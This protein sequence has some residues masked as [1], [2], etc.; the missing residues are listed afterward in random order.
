MST[1]LIA[2]IRDELARVAVPAKAPA[3]QAY[4]KSDMPYL[5]VSTD[6]TQNK[7]RCVSLRPRHSPVLSVL[8]EF[9][10]SVPLHY[11]Q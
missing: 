8:P 3:M 10:P 9:L 6:L 4:M 2:A 1:D 11:P 5:G 7:V